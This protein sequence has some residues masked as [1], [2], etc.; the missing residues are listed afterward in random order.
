MPARKYRGKWYVDVWVDIP[1]QGKRRIRKRSRV[2][3]KRGAEAHERD[4]IVET[5]AAAAAEGR[6]ALVTERRF[7]EYATEFMETYAVVNNKFS[8]VQSK[9]R[10]LR[11]H[12]LPAFGKFSL[13][14]IGR[15]EIEFYKAAKLKAGL[16]PKSINNHLTILRRMLVEA[17]EREY[18][19]RIPAFT[20]MKTT[21]PKFYFLSFADAERLIAAAEPA[22]KPMITFALRTGMRIGELLA[23]QRDDLDLIA[24]RVLV[25]R[26]VACNRLGTTKNRKAREIPL[27]RKTVAIMQQAQHSMGPWVFCDARGKRLTRGNTKWPLWRAWRRAGLA[28]PDKRTL[29]WHAL[30]HT[31]ASHLVMRGVPL[32]T[33]QELLGHSTIEMTMQYAHL[34]PEVKRD[35]VEK[36]ELAAEVGH[37][38]GTDATRQFQVSD[39]NDENGGGAGSRTFQ[40]PFPKTPNTTRPCTYFHCFFNQISSTS[41]SRPRPF[42]TGWIRPK[43]HRRGNDVTTP[44]CARDME[45]NG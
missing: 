34:S 24:G 37:Y 13:H 1:G 14:E 4:L 41:T 44:L 5:L 38:M 30:R 20:W 45:S 23:V 22:W 21:K 10:T 28:T 25:R 17:V 6:A 19:D 43:P 12:L 7:D 2:Q 11:L 9:E 29:G 33:I 32:K 31:F 26:A 27:G 39:N 16:S 15:R 40:R 35:A 8:E 3:S 36:L 42:G 18:L